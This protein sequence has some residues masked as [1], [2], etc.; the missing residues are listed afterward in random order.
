LGEIKGVTHAPAFRVHSTRFEGLAGDGHPPRPPRRSR[1]AE[2]RSAGEFAVIREEQ[3]APFLSP[4]RR[5]AVASNARCRNF[6]PVM[7]P[8]CG[9][10]PDA[11]AQPL[12][13]FE[14]ATEGP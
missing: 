4:E 5:P 7:T 11:A 3:G 10:T 9:P 8:F 6:K 1:D 14:R 12:P 2:L 13:L